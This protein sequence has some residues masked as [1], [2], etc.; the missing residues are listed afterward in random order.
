MIVAETEAGD[1]ILSSVYKSSSGLL[2]YGKERA[3]RLRIV[4]L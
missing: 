2:G 3:G 1:V 4:K